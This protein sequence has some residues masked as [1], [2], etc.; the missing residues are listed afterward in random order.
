MKW[1]PKEKVTDAV[2][3]NY[4][5]SFSDAVHYVDLFDKE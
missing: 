3:E 5:V 1:I 4:D 2:V